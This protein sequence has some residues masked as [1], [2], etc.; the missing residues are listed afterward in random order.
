M[1]IK[2]YVYF[3][4]FSE[5]ATADE[6]GSY[7]GMPP[8]RVRIR[9]SRVADPPHPRAHG[10]QLLCDSPGLR[11][12][13]QAS[14]VLERIPMI[15]DRLA[16]IRVELL[17]E[18]GGCVLQLVRDF[19]DEEGEEEELSPPDAPLQKLSGQHQLLGWHLDAELLS[20]LV[21]VGA[22]IDAD[23]YG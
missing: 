9:G 5:V 3:S 10:W 11:I 12:D 20:L 15:E 19:D 23:E 17:G 16:R 7:L 22:H 6:I 21:R 4:V 2:Q 1:R 13:E 18:G 14:A 8:D